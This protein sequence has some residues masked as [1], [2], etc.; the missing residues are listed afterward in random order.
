MGYVY[1]ITNTVSGKAYIGISTHEPEKRRIREHLS[2]RGNQLIAKAIKKY[3]KD[4]FIYETLE[5]NVFDEF[6][7]D[8]EV[9]YIA[10]HNT[11]S[12]NGYNLDS[13]G[14]LPSVKHRQ[15]I[16]DGLKGRKVTTETRLKISSAQK[17][18]KRKPLSAE[19]RQKISDSNKG[20]T[21]SADARLKMSESHKGEKNPMFG[22]K[23]KDSPSFGK[24]RSADTRRKQSEAA[25]KRTR[26]PEYRRK[27]SEW[28]QH[29]K[30]LPAKSLFFSLPSNMLR[31]EKI[32]QVS[33]TFS[34]D[35][36]TVRNWIQ[37]W[38]VGNNVGNPKSDEHLRR[39]PDYISA[40][41]FFLSLDTNIPL[42]EKRKLL[43]QKFPCV[44]GGTIRAWV[45]DWI[46]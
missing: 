17:G 39:H 29:S 42:R 35:R 15:K 19:H 24:K 40:R 5:A 8:L 26:C 20:K 23:G 7:P 21:M 43:Y 1:K 46:K 45:R 36:K 28:L 34:V 18:K 32:K 44:S 6:L 2:G 4:A 10:N 9:A 41:T 31:S 30:F 37:K 3:G 25:K 33:Q 13:G 12:P 11:L 16:S 14:K 22:K 38:N 27:M